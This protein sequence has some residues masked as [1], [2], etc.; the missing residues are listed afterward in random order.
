MA[1][2][3]AALALAAMATVMVPGAP[4]WLGGGGMGLRLGSRRRVPRERTAADEARI[5]AAKAK[6]AR[7]GAKRL[8]E[9]A[10]QEVQ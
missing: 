6:R 10:K 4:M 3:G 9:M 7:K 8:A 5:E 1:G 2:F